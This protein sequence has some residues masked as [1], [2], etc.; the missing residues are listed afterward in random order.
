MDRAWAGIDAGKESHWVHVMDASGT[1]LLSR[2][3]ENDAADL[4]KLIEEA[5]CLAQEIVS[6]PSTSL[7]EV[8]RC[9]WRSCGSGAR[10]SVTFPVSPSTVLARPTVGSPRPILKTPTSHC[11]SGSY[12]IRPRRTGA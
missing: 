9:S 2:R 11:R 4:S 12:E 8:R 5:L 1:Q 7:V 3:V 10:E 6:G